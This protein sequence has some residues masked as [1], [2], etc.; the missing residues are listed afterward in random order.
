MNIAYPLIFWTGIVL[1][2]AGVVIMV[3]TRRKK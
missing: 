1:M 2:I 3:A